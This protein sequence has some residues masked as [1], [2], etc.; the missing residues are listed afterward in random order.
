MTTVAEVQEA[1]ATL[2]ADLEADSA[3][4]VAEFAKL[5]KEV[6]EG[7]PAT[8]EDLTPL[9]EAIEALDARVKSAASS[10]PTE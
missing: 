6:E 7:K 4:A 8:G 10:I 5:E 2:T 3:A 1:I 9:K